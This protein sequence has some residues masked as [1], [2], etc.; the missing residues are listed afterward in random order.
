MNGILNCKTVVYPLFSLFSS[1][2][3]STPTE[4]RS[5]SLLSPFFV[6]VFVF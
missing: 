6:S 3:N 1:K 2:V 4:K 5:W